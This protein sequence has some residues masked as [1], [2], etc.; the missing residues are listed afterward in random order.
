[1]FDLGSRR[2]LVTGASGGI[3]AE[4][5]RALHAQGATV[6]LPG[7]RARALQD[8]AAELGER[9]FVLPADLSDPAAADK[10]VQDAE[11]AIVGYV[12]GE[13]TRG[14]RVAERCGRIAAGLLGAAALSRILASMVFRVS[15]RDPITFVVAPLALALVA[16]AAGYVPARRATLVDPVEAIRQE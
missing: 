15:V 10:L 4:I 7:T 3:G 13:V 16:L 12:A 6:A 9:A 5:A 1:M 14:D 11:A 8:L 2:S